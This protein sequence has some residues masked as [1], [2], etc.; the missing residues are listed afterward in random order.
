MNNKIRKIFSLLLLLLIIIFS[1][2]TQGMIKKKDKK[3]ENN[4]LMTKNFMKS[5][6]LLAIQAVMKCA[7]QLE[8]LKK[9]P[10]EFSS[11]IEIVGCWSIIFYKKCVKPSHR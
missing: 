4:F 7:S 10:K 6:K 9:Y 1:T 11:I 5:L 8:A 3:P 2:E